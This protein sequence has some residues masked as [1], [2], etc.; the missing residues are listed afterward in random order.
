MDDRTISIVPLLTVNFYIHLLDYLALL[1]DQMKIFSVVGYK[2]WRKCNQ[3]RK[4]SSKD[5]G[6]HPTL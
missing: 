6:H 4:I 1:V 5:H 2:G 3:S